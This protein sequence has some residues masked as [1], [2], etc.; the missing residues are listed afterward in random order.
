MI[1]EVGGAWGV[2]L[3]HTSGADALKVFSASGGKC[4]IAVLYITAQK[5]KRTID[6]LSQKEDFEAWTRIFCADCYGYCGINAHT[7]QKHIERSHQMYGPSP[8]PMR[9]HKKV[10]TFL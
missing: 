7:P 6:L 8:L 3:G 5:I 2:G 4:R 1:F 9:R 10:L